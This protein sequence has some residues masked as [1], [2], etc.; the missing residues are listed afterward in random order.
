MGISRREYA[1]RRGCSESGVRKAIA[2]GRITLEA[3]GTIDPVKADAQWARETDP[4]LQRGGAAL[5]AQE[6]AAAMTEPAGG[7]EAKPVPRAALNAVDEALRETGDSIPSIPAGDASGGKDMTFLRARTANEVMKAQTARV[8]LQK[9]KGELVDRARAVATLYGLARR[10]RDAWVQWP[11]RVA[12]LI[13]A[14][15]GADAHAMETAL[16]KYVRAHLAELSE[17]KVDLG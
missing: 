15:L 16:N 1:R 3:D 10:E 14:E 7:E 8:R 12:A 13:A 6:A 11:P 2:S 5:L 4:A 17:L 9:L